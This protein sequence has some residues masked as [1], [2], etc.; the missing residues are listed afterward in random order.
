MIFGKNSL[1]AKMIKS[2]KRIGDFVVKPILLGKGGFSEVYQGSCIKTGDPVAI[3]VV[4][5]SNKDILKRLDIEINLVRDLNHKNIVKTIH[6]LK[7]E[8]YT[9]IVMEKCSSDLKG[10]LRFNKL[11]HQDILKIMRQIA[12]GVE[13]LYERGI[14]HRDLKLTNLLVSGD[15][16]KIADFGFAVK[17]ESNMTNTICG[18]PLYM[19]PEVLTH[20]MYDSRIDLWSVGVIMFE[21]YFERLPYSAKTL[22]EL[23][24]KYINTLEIPKTINKNAHNLM[25]SLLQQS[26]DDRI[27]FDD[28]F[29]HVYFSK[30]TLDAFHLESDSSPEL[31]TP[32][33][34]TQ[35]IAIK[36]NG[37]SQACSLPNGE[38]EYGK[39]AFGSYPKSFSPKEMGEVRM[40]Q[41]IYMCGSAVKMIRDYF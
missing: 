5:N 33:L 20:T 39:M 22:M 41:E 16:I 29:S 24:K 15:C 32:F 2:E 40:S 25:T 28:F 35:P 10:W 6:V 14:V 12:D 7:S 3:K 4:S 37:N 38:K 31:I 1:L 9:Y 30:D 27:S 11:E 19:A 13:Y 8:N 23:K 36:K 26:P 18:T 17:I 21:L 34:V